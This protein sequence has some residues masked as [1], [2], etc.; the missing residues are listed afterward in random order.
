M[1]PS[2]SPIAHE[3]H[4]G[5]ILPATSAEGP[6][7]RSALWVAGC[8][9]RCEGCFNAHLFDR[10]TATV[11]GVTELL[12]ALTADPSIEGTTFLGGEPFDQAPALA[13]LAASVR[14]AGLSVMTFTGYRYERLVSGRI[15]GAT[16]LLGQTDLL[17]DGPFLRHKVDNR[18]AWIGSTNQRLFALTDRYRHEVQALAAGPDRIEVTVSATGF[19]ALNGWAEPAL[20][21]QLFD[22][23][24]V[25]RQ[26]RITAK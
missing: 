18:R 9:I 5:R 13:R 19:V 4:Y 12:A 7:L 25:G 10:T 11:T 26:T 17:V 1:S 22:A 3:I 8:S 24:S 6:G 14:Q 15:P 23:I 2:S 16:E 21:N 20:M